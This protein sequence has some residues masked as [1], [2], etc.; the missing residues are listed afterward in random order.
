MLFDAHT[1]VHELQKAHMKW[2]NDDL[3]LG[4]LG[5]NIALIFKYNKSRRNNAKMPKWLTRDRW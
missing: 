4:K 1:H 3:F 5:D 2:N